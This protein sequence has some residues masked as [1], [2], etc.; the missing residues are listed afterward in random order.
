[1]K[2]RTKL[3]FWFTALVA[4]I[5]GIGALWGWLG[6]RTSVY[7]QGE[8]EVHDKQKEV[9][10]FIST[11]S[12]EFKHQ[13]LNFDLRENA[14]NLDQIFANDQTARYD[15]IFIQLSDTQ[16][17]LISR[18][19]NLGNLTL[20]IHP[21]K[22]LSDFHFMHLQPEKGLD[23]AILY[24]SSPIE[25]GGKTVGYLQLGL[26]MNKSELFLQQ[27]L[28][29]DGLGLLFSIA[30]SLVLGQWLAQRALSPMLQM[31]E[32]V[33]EMAGQDLFKPLNT[34]GLS[35]DEIG[36]LAETF[37]GLMQRIEKVFIAQQRFLS[38]ASHEFKTPL[39]AIRG[40]AQLLE[41]RGPSH[42]EILSKSALTIIRECTRL[43][44]LTEDLLLL[45]RLEGHAE[46]M[47]PV[48]M[49]QL[50]EEIFEDLSPLHP[51]LKIK[52]SPEK[53]NIQGNPDSLYRVLLN[54][55]DNAF[56]ADAQAE[57]IL[58]SLRQEQEVIVQV[59]DRG[60]GIPALHL[61]HLFERFYRIDSDRNRN[62]GGSGIGLA[63]VAE[64]VKFHQG[65]IRVQSQEGQGTIFFLHFPLI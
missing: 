65:S 48:N 44:R 64:V 51:Q 28:I 39:T 63:L 56:K 3:T 12:E 15:N 16:G 18:S 8:Q 31:T 61:P 55:L 27:M 25:V 11:V 5:V 57:V 52:I 4:I 38:D 6:L 41:K 2:I 22:H 7:Y 45:A 46:K 54:L 49:G 26:S 34:T 37:N 13:N 62:S 36:I 53:L 59:Q 42:P 60:P 19:S 29:F 21:Q 50:L 10:L 23:I 17:H 20:P 40:H 47:V 24:S 14:R 32:Q 43:S 9:Q 58:S 35:R 30:L 33:R 1:M